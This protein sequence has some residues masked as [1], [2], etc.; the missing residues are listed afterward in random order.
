M[1]LAEQRLKDYLYAWLN[2]N[3]YNILRI[4]PIRGPATQKQA[5]GRKM[6][7]PSIPDIYAKRKGQQFYYYIEA[8]GGKPNVQTFYNVLGE[9]VT[10]R[11]ARTPA[12]YAIAL[13]ETF[14]KTILKNLPYETW[15]NLGKSNLSIYILL[16]D[17]SGNVQEFAPTKAN[18]KKI[19]RLADANTG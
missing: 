2:K 11:A 3:G 13:P 10:K 9:I 16:V 12:R 8:K 7:S 14:S 17:K 18:Y 4:P 6:K 5:R 1:P 19:S 15:K